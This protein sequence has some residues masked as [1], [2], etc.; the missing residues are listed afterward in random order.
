MKS[1]RRVLRADASTRVRDWPLGCF[2]TPEEGLAFQTAGA[3]MNHPR[4]PLG[5]P[6]GMGEP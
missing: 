5:E 2:R 6:G 3:M 4:G 1:L